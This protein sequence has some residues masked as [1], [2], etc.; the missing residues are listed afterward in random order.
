MFKLFSM[1]KICHKSFMVGNLNKLIE[2]YTLIWQLQIIN[3]IKLV[4]LQFQLQ[5][6]DNIEVLK[7]PLKIFIIIR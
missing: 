4:F 3:F 1:F 2:I 6:S 7:L 5:I